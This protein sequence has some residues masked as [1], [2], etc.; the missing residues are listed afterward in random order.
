MTGHGPSGPYECVLFHATGYGLDAVT[1]AVKKVTSH[2]TNK[3]RM[4]AS[5][6]ERDPGD[7]A[8]RDFQRS[9]SGIPIDI[10]S[11]RDC[12]KEERGKWSPT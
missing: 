1:K 6:V 8:S 9:D 2:A 7:N 10:T 4:F 5:V 11:T 12:L 3:L